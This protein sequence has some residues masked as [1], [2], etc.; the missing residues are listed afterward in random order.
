M[1]NTMTKKGNRIIK[2]AFLYSI[3]ESL[4]RLGVNTLRMT[5]YES[6]KD[7]VHFKNARRR[8]IL[9]GVKHASKE[10]LDDGIINL[11]LLAKNP[12]LDVWDVRLNINTF[13][14]DTLE[15]I[16]YEV[17]DW[18]RGE[19]WDD[20]EDYRRELVANWLDTYLDK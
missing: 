20:W 13:R 9:Y 6:D 18:C 12:D 3:N 1:E 5:G 19:D 2:F 8:C 7:R 14:V 4:E 17:Y 11:I 10:D 15:K 16:A